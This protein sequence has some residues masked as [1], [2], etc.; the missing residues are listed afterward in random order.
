M[1]KNFYTF[2]QL[3]NILSL[4]ERN[5]DNNLGFAVLY[6]E[7]GSWLASNVDVDNAIKFMAYHKKN[8]GKGTDRLYP[9]T[10][11]NINI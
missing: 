3:S 9:K 5:K 2:A 4:I 11:F 1:N 7:F 6:T 8:I 10:L